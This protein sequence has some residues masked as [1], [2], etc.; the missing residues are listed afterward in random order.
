M[1]KAYKHEAVTKIN[2]IM[3]SLENTRLIGGR[4]KHSNVFSRAVLM[5]FFFL[6]CNLFNYKG[7]RWRPKNLKFE[8][9]VDIVLV[10]L[11]M[12]NNLFPFRTESL[13]ASAAKIVFR[14]RSAKIARR[15]HN[16]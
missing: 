1:L 9:L 16:V 4:Y 3:P 2:C 7:V 8:Y 6:I 5:G 10:I 12:W 13:N 14:Q 15:Q 11:A